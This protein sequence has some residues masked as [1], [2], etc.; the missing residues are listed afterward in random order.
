ME[1]RVLKAVEALGVYEKVEAEARG[2]RRTCFR[3]VATGR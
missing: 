1:D 2:E 3:A